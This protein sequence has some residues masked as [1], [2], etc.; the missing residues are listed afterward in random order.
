MESRYCAGIL[1]RRVEFL[2][3]VSTCWAGSDD[4]FRNLIDP[5][6]RVADWLP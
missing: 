6:E 1:V 2:G 4:D 5:Y 3:T